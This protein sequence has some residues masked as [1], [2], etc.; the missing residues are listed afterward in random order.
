MSI[1]NALNRIRR[2]AGIKRGIV[3]EGNVSDVNLVD[4]KLRGT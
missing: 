3:V 1:T 4:R 2:E